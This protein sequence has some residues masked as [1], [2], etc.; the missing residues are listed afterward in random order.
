MIFRHCQAKHEQKALVKQ[1]DNTRVHTIRKPEVKLPM[2]EER[3]RKCKR[4]RQDQEEKGRSPPLLSMSWRRPQTPVPRR[5]RGQPPLAVEGREGLWRV[6]SE[7]GQKNTCSS[8]LETSCGTPVPLMC[9]R[10]VMT[11]F[12][13]MG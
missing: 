9:S 4:K 5:E 3:H 12:S 6:P 10:G 1:S 7:R 8:G 11:V 13:G 2:E